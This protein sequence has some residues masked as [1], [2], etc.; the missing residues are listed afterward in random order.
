MVESSLPPQ[1]SRIGR[2]F[3]EYL[4][5]HLLGGRVG[6]GRGVW[7]EEGVGRATP[8]ASPRRQLPA[9]PRPCGEGKSIVFTTI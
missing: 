2:R 7:N 5:V 6:E 3:I 8:E 9:D 1:D 4:F